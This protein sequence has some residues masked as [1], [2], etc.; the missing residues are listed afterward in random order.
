MSQVYHVGK[1]GSEGREVTN[2]KFHLML[3]EKNVDKILCK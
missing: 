2:R 3:S 1:G